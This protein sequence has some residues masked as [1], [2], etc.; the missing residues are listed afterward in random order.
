MKNNAI[1]S[2]LVFDAPRG[3]EL[4][5]IG[6]DLALETANAEHPEW[7]ERCWQLFWQWLNRK[8][9]YFEFLLEEFRKYC[10]D[11]DLIE[12]PRSERAFAFLVKKASKENMIKCIGIEK[13]KNV[14]A[15]S[16][17]ASRWIKL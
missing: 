7:K 8:P 1:Q 4:A 14:K 5:N 6:L 11:M 17:N 13:V 16:A 12:R 9:K 10:Y 15:H 2:Q 3:Q